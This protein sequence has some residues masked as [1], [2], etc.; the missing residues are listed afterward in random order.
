MLLNIGGADCKGALQCTLHNYVF[1]F[2]IPL[3]R[4]LPTLCLDLFALN[5]PTCFAFRFTIFGKSTPHFAHRSLP[6][7][8]RGIKAT[9]GN[10]E[11]LKVHC[12]APYVAN[13]LHMESNYINISRASSSSLV[14]RD[15]ASTT[16]NL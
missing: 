5:V 7:G 2:Y 16:L 14:E 13:V 12:N 4:A 1:H 9:F 15:D 8:A 10:F 3:T 11:K 6:Q